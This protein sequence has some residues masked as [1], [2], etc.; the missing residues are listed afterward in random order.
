VHLL[1]FNT[2]NVVA[3][4]R[5]WHKCTLQTRYSLW[6]TVRLSDGERTGSRHQ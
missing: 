4:E 5:A 1:F 6:F 3:V 2:Q